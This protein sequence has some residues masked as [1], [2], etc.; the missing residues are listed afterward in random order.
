ML[1]HIAVNPD[2][3]VNEIAAEMSLTKRTVWGLIGDLRR[4]GMLHIR[5]EGRRH[6]YSV[7]LDAPFLCPGVNGYQLRAL[8]GHIAGP[9][10]NGA[11]PS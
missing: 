5:K 3:T 10:R 6:H 9:A 8:L 1:F 7:N 11:T 2:C 4:E